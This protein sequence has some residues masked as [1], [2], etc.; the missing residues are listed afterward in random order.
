MDSNQLL[1]IV[2]K[3]DRD[4]LTEYLLQ[5]GSDAKYADENG[6]C[7]L[8][9]AF[10]GNK[11]VEQIKK[12][13]AYDVDLNVTYNGNTILDLECAKLEPNLKLI[14]LLMDNWADANTTN[15]KTTPLAILTVRNNIAGVKLMLSY[16]SVDVNQTCNNGVT[17]LR[18]A[19]SMGYLTIVMLLLDAGADANLQGTWGSTPLMRAIDRGHT[20]LVPI[21]L[22]H[23]VAINL[24]DAA[25]FTAL[26][27]ACSKD[28][29][30]S[31][32][33]LLCAGA[34][35]T[36]KDNEG[37]TAIEYC[38]LSETKW[39]IDNKQSGENK[40]EHVSKYFK[41]PRSNDG[42]LGYAGSK[43]QTWNYTSKCWTEFKNF[44]WIGKVNCEYTE[45]KMQ[46]HQVEHV[47][48]RFNYILRTDGTKIENP[49]ID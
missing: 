19:C 20:D 12:L 5:T 48:I 24:Q 16:P 40:E 45:E 37:K 47:R 23:K 38:T 43:Y 39:I 21:I 10:D 4:D 8:F 13:I 42:L 9:H 31:V 22:Q 33:H 14:K 34:D 44:P 11:S 2:V 46:Y 30:A 7:V 26:H 32:Y 41:S 15:D 18:F 36:V 35:L 6:K 29:I 1:C 17:A 27:H 49:Y 25:G 3:T 28:Q